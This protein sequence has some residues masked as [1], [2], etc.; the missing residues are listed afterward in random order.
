MMLH[1]SCAARGADAVLFLGPPGSGKSDLVLRLLQGGWRLV[2]DD[3]VC[4]DA[5]AAGLHAQAPA[6]LAGLLEVRGLGIFAGLPVADPPPPLRLVVEC[7]APEGP[8]A[9][10]PRLPEPA[11]FEHL[12]QRLPRIALHAL[13]AS[14][15]AKVG[16]ALDAATG[17]ARQ[18]CGAFT[19]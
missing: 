9:A 16:W 5:G 4:L 3:Q 18:H 8:R 11:A 19:A 10:V 2:G 15:P 17:R 13:E 6:A 7:A 12:G 14:A 1:A